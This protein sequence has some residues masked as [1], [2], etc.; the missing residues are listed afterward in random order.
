MASLIPQVHKLIYG[1][2]ATSVTY[3]FAELGIA[4][5]FNGERR[6]V[7]YLA[8]QTGTATEMLER[9]LR[10]AANLDLIE[11]DHDDGYVLSPLGDLLRSDHPQSQRAAARLNGAPYR[12][13]PWGQLTDILKQGPSSKYADTAASGTLD[14]LADKPELKAVFHQ[15][16]TDLSVRD[17]QV[18]SKSFPFDQ[19]KHIIDVGGGHGSFLT[20]IL[21]SAGNSKGTLFDRKDTFEQLRSSDTAYKPV[22]ALETSGKL[23]LIGGDF[24]DSVPTDGDLYIIKNTIHNWPQHQTKKLLKSLSEAMRHNQT[25]ESANADKRLLIIEYLVADEAGSEMANWLDLNFMILVN[26]KSRTQKEYTDIAADAGL[27]LAG[28]HPTKIGRKILEFKLA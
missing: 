5:C 25:S 21:E 9:F 20:A 10:C 24:F 23:R 18:L 6:F 7:D 26:G 16:M 15:A 1:N 12:Y 4:D 14:Y 2:W 3:T 27:E 19:F 8:E 11:T 22:Q 13:H 28:V 17:D